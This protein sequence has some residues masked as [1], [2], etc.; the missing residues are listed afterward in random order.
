[1]TPWHTCCGRRKCDFITIREANATISRSDL[2]LFF[3]LLPGVTR[4]PG[5]LQRVL[6]YQRWVGLL[7]REIPSLGKG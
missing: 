5:F 3:P 2:V 6:A 1:M 4:K 7:T